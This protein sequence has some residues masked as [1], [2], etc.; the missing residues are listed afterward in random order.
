[1]NPSSAQLGLWVGIFIVL[2]SAAANVVAIIATFRTQRRR[3]QMED[4][5][6]TTTHV[7]KVET[8][9]EALKKQ[10]VVNG[11]T[12]KAAIEGKVEA[13]RLEVKRDVEKVQEKINEVGLEV[14]ACAKSCEMTNTQVLHLVDAVRRLGSGGGGHGYRMNGE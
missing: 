4:T 9:L 3:V 14:S 8:E 12:R 13:L 2:L 5:Y 11:D 10:I 1:M 6:A 7:S